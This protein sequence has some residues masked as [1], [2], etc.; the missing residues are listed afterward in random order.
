MTEEYNTDIALW[1]LNFLLHVCTRFIKQKLLQS[2]CLLIDSYWTIELT[3][4]L[5]SIKQQIVV[6]DNAVYRSLSYFLLSNITPI[7]PITETTGKNSLLHH[8]YTMPW[9]HTP[10]NIVG[11][12]SHEFFI[13][14]WSLTIIHQGSQQNHF[15]MHPFSPSI[16]TFYRNLKTIIVKPV[17]SFYKPKQTSFGIT[18]TKYFVSIFPLSFVQ[19]YH[20]SI[21]VICFTTNARRRTLNLTC[22]I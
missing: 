22:T 11:T 13:W 10:Q 6:C 14:V 20:L 8:L 19:M 5:I 4:R 15:Y 21:K 17:F 12:Y 1:N 16:N 3:Y 18:T 2:W 9:S 7:P